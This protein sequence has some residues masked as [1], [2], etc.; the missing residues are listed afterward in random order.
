MASKFFRVT[1]VLFL[2]IFLFFFYR[3]SENGRYEQIG[4][5]IFDTRNG[6]VISDLR[7]N[8][9]GQKN[10]IITSQPSQHTSYSAPEP[11]SKIRKLYDYLK[12]QNFVSSD[13][14]KFEADMQDDSRLEKVFDYLK[15]QN[16]V[17]SETVEE[18]R[19]KM[20]IKRRLPGGVPFL[21]P[22]DTSK[23]PKASK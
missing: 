15:K 22:D 19:K 8:I 17:R 16:K 6:E 13:F 7:N 4:P 14:E 18:F 23:Y 20:G 1:V 21:H 10:E 3:Y 9:R 5:L 11:Q 2:I 12:L